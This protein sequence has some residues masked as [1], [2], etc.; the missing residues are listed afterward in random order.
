MKKIYTKTGDAGMT[1]LRNGVRVPKDDIRI[2]TN[3]MLDEL[4]ALLGVCRSSLPVE[5]ERWRML[6]AIQTE[7]MSVMS[8]VATSSGKVNPKEL[9]VAELTRRMEEAMDRMHEEVGDAGHFILPG[10]T[11]LSARLHFA[12]AVARTVERRLWTLNRQD[13]V[14][15]EILCFMNRLSDYL[16]LSARLEIR[17]QRREEEFYVK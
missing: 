12:R 16:F 2:E 14:N 15:D 7:L 6:Y 17:R 1:S 10:G 3:G 13:D 11:L 4:N 8:H 9:H 5:D